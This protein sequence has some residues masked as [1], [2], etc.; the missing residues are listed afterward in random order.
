M[1]RYW[2]INNS[3]YLLCYFRNNFSSNKTLPDDN[4]EYELIRGRKVIVEDMHLRRAYLG[5]ASLEG[6]RYRMLQFEGRVRGG[7]RSGA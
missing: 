3:I 2:E 5:R 6:G 4:T 7:N 1:Y